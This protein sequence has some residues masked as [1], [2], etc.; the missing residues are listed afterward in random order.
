VSLQQDNQVSFEIASQAT[1]VVEHLR[2]VLQQYLQKRP[3]LSV[4]GISKRCSVS[5]P[6]LR[7]IMSQKVKTTPQIT[8]LLDTLTF[9]SQTSSVRAIVAMYPG[10][11]ADHLKEAMPYLDEFDQDYSNEINE[12]LRDP[13]K[14]L[15]YK[16]ALNHAGV[17]ED[18]VIELYGN[19][20]L[21]LLNDMIEKGYIKKTPNQRCR[22]K[23]KTNS[24]SH[25]DFVRNFKA[26][27]DFIKPNKL[28]H[29]KPFNPYFVNMSDSLTPEA[30]EQIRRILGKTDKKLRKILADPN[31]K[32]HLPVFFLGAMDTLDPQSAAEWVEAEDQEPLR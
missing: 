14:Y 26:V 24:S 22:A 6:T 31:S 9:I 20:G 28:R 32:G 29:R 13:V 7:R 15:I 3:H 19:H 16:L 27:A 30:Y 8:T 1:S 5:E 18:K 25:Q 12:E 21:R 23:V 10:P 2:S 11:I 4:N 17:S